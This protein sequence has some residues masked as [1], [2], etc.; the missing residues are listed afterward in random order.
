MDDFIS[1]YSFIWQKIYTKK[2]KKILGT[3][4]RFS[5]MSTS[6]A[7]NLLVHASQWGLNPRLGIKDSE[8]LLLQNLVTNIRKY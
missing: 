2:S 5:F 8:K 6:E 7:R 4:V 1:Q 3:V